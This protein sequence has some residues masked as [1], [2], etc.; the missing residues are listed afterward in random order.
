MIHK[1][2]LHNA[3]SDCHSGVCNYPHLF[4]TALFKLVSSTM[5]QLV[6]RQKQ[7]E[8]FYVLCRFDW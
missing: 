7:A 6:K 4:A 1:T 2:Y 8:Q 3:T 5:F